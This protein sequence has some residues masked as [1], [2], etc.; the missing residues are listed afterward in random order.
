MGVI[1]NYLILA[2]VMFGLVTSIYLGLKTIKL[3]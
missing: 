1:V 2:G 3:I